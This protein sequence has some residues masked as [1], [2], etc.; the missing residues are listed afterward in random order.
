MPRQLVN[1]LTTKERRDLAEP[2]E[3]V[4]L[5]KLLARFDP[6]ALPRTPWVVA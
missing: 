6:S 5:P 1:G 4:S 3:P 2:D